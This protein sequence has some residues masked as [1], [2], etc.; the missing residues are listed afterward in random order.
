[1]NEVWKDVPGFGGHYQASSLGRIR[2]K[3][4]LVEK[5]TRHGGVM[6]QSYKGRLLSLINRK[7]YRQVKIGVDGVKMNVSVHTMVLLAFHGPKP[8]G[9]EGCHRNGNPAD[10]RE[11][12]L[13]W[14]TPESNAQ[15]RKDHGNYA[16]GEQHPMAKL[17]V[18]RVRRI[19]DGRVTC[20]Q[21]QEDYGISMSQ[22]YRVRR[23]ETWSEACQ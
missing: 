9:H 3:D 7:G 2:S 15:D 22:F 11:C 21:A 12:N 6:V 5:R 19:R 18:D 14:G 1:M 8:E 16:I 17:T 23:G 13:R 20:K 4:R 10:N